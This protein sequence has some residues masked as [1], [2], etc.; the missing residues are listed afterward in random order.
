MES[1]MRDILFVLRTFEELM[2]KPER[3]IPMKMMDS[4][5]ETDFIATDD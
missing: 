3:R 1:E 2:N 5:V 4:N